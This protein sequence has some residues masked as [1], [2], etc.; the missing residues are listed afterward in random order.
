M[1]EAHIVGDVLAAIDFSD[2]TDDIL[3]EGL[4]LARASGG[5]LHLV[6]VAAGEPDLA[7]YDKDDI[8]PF[9]RQARAGQLTDEHQRLRSMAEALGGDGVE[10]VPLVVMGPT[11]QRIQEAADHVG[12]S[13]VVIGS[14]GHGGLHHL[15]VGSVTE[16]VVRHADRPVVVVPVRPRA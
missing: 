8:S 16:E 1:T 2:R 3:A 14:H 7:G 15:L 4:A 6:H 13:H 10:V 11:A 12:A 5:V 9:T